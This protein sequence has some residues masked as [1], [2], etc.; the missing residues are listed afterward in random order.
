MCM[1][2]SNDT[3]LNHQFNLNSTSSI[4]SLNAHMLDQMIQILII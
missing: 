1:I 3:N 2:G 4:N